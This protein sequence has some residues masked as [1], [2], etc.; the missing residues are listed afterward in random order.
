M[1]LQ[2]IDPICLQS[3]QGGFSGA[4]HCFRRKILRNLS[5]PAPFVPVMH[6][7]VADLRRYHNLITLVGKRLGDQLFAQS[8]SVGI[9][10]I[11]E[12]NTEIEGLPQ[13]IDGLLLSE[14]APPSCRHR[15]HPKSDFAYGKIGISISAIIHCASA[16]ILREKLKVN[17]SSANRD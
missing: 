14:A 17:G 12:R 6:K 10:C 16:T 1:E 3:F 8:I 7:I 4:N 11:E 2:K 15:P 9:S 13:K 5:L